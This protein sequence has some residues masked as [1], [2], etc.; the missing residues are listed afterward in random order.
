MEEIKYICQAVIEDG[1]CTL[2][3][4]VHCDPHDHDFLDDCVQYDCTG[5]IDLVED[6]QIGHYCVP[7]DSKEKKGS[8]LRDKLERL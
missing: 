8:Y 4:C 3:H 1:G 5:D 7:M 2:R 6:N